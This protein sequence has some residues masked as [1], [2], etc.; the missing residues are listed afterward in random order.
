MPS[1]YM[2]DLLLT[3]HMFDMPHF[4]ESGSLRGCTATHLQHTATH[5]NTLQHTTT[6]CNALQDI[7]T[8]GGLRGCTAAHSDTLQ[9]TA[10]HCN[11]LQHT[12]PLSRL[13]A[14]IMGLFCKRAV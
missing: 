8:D 12:D 3:V 14:K 5:C 1:A 7:A 2:S 13:L 4:L 9:L 10:T 6:H 11:T